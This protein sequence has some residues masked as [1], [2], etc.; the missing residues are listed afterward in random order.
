MIRG[1]VVQDEDLLQGLRLRGQG[2]KAFIQKRGTVE[3]RD[4]RRDCRLHSEPRKLSA[5]S[6]FDPL[7]LLVNAAGN[8]I[9]HDASEKFRTKPR[10]RARRGRTPMQALV[11]AL[12]AM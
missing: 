4:N 12:S 1:P 5:R 2:G 9:G 3:G 10:D 8:G 6:I 7:V 11:A